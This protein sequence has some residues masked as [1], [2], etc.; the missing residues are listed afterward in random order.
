MLCVCRHRLGLTC[1]IKVLTKSNFV[2]KRFF[3][4]SCDITQPYHVGLDM[5]WG[6][7]LGL[8]VHDQR[9]GLLDRRWAVFE[10]TYKP[11]NL[12]N[13]LQIICHRTPRLHVAR[14][15]LTAVFSRSHGGEALET[16]WELAKLALLS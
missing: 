15:A 16:P 6:L 11:N 14:L 1:F 2:Y 4:V 13:F 12:E 3:A 10:K 8:Y 7:I 5:S 9:I